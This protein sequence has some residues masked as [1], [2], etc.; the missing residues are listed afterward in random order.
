MAFIAFVLYL[1]GDIMKLSPIQVAAWTSER[2]HAR[3]LP[4]SVRRWLFRQSPISVGTFHLLHELANRVRDDRDTYP[5]DL[6][7]NLLRELPEVRMRLIANHLD[8]YLEHDRLNSESEFRVNLAI[9]S[10][11]LWIVL[12]ATLSPWLLLGFVVST[13]L[14]LNGIRAL[15]EANAILVQ[16]LVAGVVDSRVY[17]EEV[18]RHHSHSHGE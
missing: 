3:W 2:R 15:R 8:V 4:Q 11:T 18:H 12:A 17:A 9:F 5:A 14:F 6:V 16:G 13:V 10:V 1:I 7:D